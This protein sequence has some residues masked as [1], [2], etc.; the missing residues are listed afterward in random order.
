MTI[1]KLKIDARLKSAKND[2]VSS[3]I[4]KGYVAGVLDL[5]SQEGQAV[6]GFK[7][8]FNEAL[9]SAFAAAGIENGKKV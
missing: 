2:L 7:G 6:T 9:R 4:G 1:K 5:L 8:S 3:S